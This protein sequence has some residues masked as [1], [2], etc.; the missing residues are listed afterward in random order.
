M[1]FVS[2][3]A[4]TLLP[5]EAAWRSRKVQYYKGNWNSIES[6]IPEFELK[7]FSAGEQ[8]PSNPFLQTVMRKPLSPAERYMPIGVVSHAYSL[9]PHCEVANLCR[10]GIIDAGIDS[11]ELEYEI[12]LSELGEWM[13]F[14]IYLPSRYEFV[15]DAGNK[16]GLR[17]ECF[18]SVDGSARLV[19]VFGWLRFVCS[20]GLVIGETKIEIKEKHGERLDLAEIAARIQP[21]L[22]AALEDGAKMRAWQSQKVEIEAVASWADNQLAEKWG[23]KAA[24]R[25][26]HICDSGKDVELDDPFAGGPATRKP[27][28][29]VASVPG[30]PDRASTKYDVAQAMSFVASNRRNTEERL[31]FQYVIQTL[32]SQLPSTGPAGQSG[33]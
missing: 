33:I 23:K 8:E 9:A 24:A 32:L 17:L 15:D 13:N 19:I 21:A 29:Y 3:A 12:G 25:V 30:A 27:I 6:I 14:R 10:K 1:N 20:N 22:N 11:E 16:L 31:T 26:F 5:G 2:T 18:N 7:P 4:I 28:R